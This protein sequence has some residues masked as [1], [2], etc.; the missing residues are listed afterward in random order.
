MEKKAYFPEG[1]PDEDFRSLLFR[2]KSRI[3]ADTQYPFKRIMI[4]LF[5][6]NA[7]KPSIYPCNLSLFAEKINSY[8]SEESIIFDHTYYSL[9]HPFLP[10][11]IDKLMFESML[12]KKMNANAASY[13]MPIDEKHY[14]FCPECL[15]SDTTR[16]GESYI[17]RV[18][19]INFVHICPL[20]HVILIKH[21]S[22][23][24]Q[25]L[26]DSDNNT[27]QPTSDSCPLCR[28]TLTPIKA[29]NNEV[30][31]FLFNMATDVKTLLQIT[32]HPQPLT[33][34]KYDVL[35]GLKGYHTYGNHKFYKNKVISSDIVSFYKMEN[36]KTINV[37]ENYLN[38][39]NFTEAN[40]IKRN[41]LV[42]I[43]L[44]RFLCGSC[45]EFINYE[46][47]SLNCP[48]Y[49][50]NGPWDCINPLCPD[51]NEKVIKYCKKMINKNK[52]EK[53][54]HASFICPTCG[55]K[56]VIDAGE[57]KTRVV[58]NGD[59]WRKAL[60]DASGS[61]QKIMQLA[62]KTGKT[63][64]RIRMDI[65]GISNSF[66]MN[67][68]E[69]QGPIRKENTKKEILELLEK[70]EFLTRKEIAVTIGNDFY[71]LRSEE[72]DWLLNILPYGNNG[73]GFK[74]K[75]WDLEDEKL[76]KQVIEIVDELRENNHPRR[77]VQY[78]IIRCI[79]KSASRFSNQSDR[80]P[81]TFETI[82]K[83]T[84]SHEEYLIRRIPITANQLKKIR[85]HL[86]ISSFLNNYRYKNCSDIVLEHV[87]QFFN[88]M[89]EEV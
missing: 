73:N 12:I 51:Y 83:L 2:Y 56:Y 67:R 54:L 42:N 9:Y 27:Y 10:N 14:K 26:A 53:P 61:R 68:N 28:K 89:K 43:L 50:G 6:T 37:T 13:I 87:T 31:N 41:P 45:E 66:K 64:E 3:G 48:I 74:P 22:S 65:S 77:I 4:D 71:K 72:P 86:T 47:P 52:K 82:K 63:V 36:L 88:Q 62:E 30:N 18:H 80:L 11:E 23:C 46:V 34:Y 38:K 81:K 78:T 40:G 44:M 21:C 59:L 70:D 75:D 17:H 7:N 15:F 1:Y 19:Q 32:K 76:S 85:T 24:K 33:L 39:L 55:C 16:F 49:W 25:L 8:K 5:D 58:N 69:K 60:T 20:H 57:S 84:E 35:F 29:E 79:T